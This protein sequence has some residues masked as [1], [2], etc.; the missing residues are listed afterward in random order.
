MN[1]QQRSLF[2][3]AIN[4]ATKAGLIDSIL[5]DRKN[6]LARARR[7]YK[8]NLA[9]PGDCAGDEK[10]L[11]G[12]AVAQ[13]HVGTRAGWIPETQRIGVAIVNLL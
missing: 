3:Q 2:W 1:T 7:A 4:A 11:A 9:D 8:R 13:A 6:F 10:L 5:Y 12:L